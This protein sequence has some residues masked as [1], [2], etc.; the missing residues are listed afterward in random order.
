MTVPNLPDRAHGRGSRPRASSRLVVPLAR[1][2]GLPARRMGGAAGKLAEGNAMRDPGRTASTAAALMIGIALV[3]FVGVLAQG[4]R[5]SNSDA[6]EQQIQ[7][8]LVVTFY[9]PLSRGRDWQLPKAVAMLLEHRPAT[10]PVGIVT[11]ASRPAETVVLTS[12]GELRP[13]D[14]TMLAC[15]VVGSSQSTVVA[16][17]MVTPRGYRWAAP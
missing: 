14:V 3:T 2:V 17:R 15:V 6:I 8:D 5:E 1:I 12:L 7:A 16:G 9:N 11:D 4:L 10:T 13:E